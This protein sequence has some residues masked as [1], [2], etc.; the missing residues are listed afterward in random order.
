M[1]KNSIKVLIVI[2]SLFTLVWTNIICVAAL[3]NPHSIIV[4]PAE[5]GTIEISGYN[6]PD[7][8][9]NIIVTPDQGYILDSLSVRKNIY[10]SPTIEKTNF[11]EKITLS[12]D[13]VIQYTLSEDYDSNDGNPAIDIE[14]TEQGKNVLVFIDL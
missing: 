2:I 5:H 14:L 9:L 1:L 13:A 3:W 6:S 8:P 11:F 12:D 4:K 7:T 10:P